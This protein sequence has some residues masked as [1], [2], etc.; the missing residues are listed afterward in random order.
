SSDSY[1]YTIELQLPTRAVTWQGKYYHGSDLKFYFVGSL[2]SFFNDTFGLT[3]QA[4]ASSLDTASTVVFG[5][6]NGVPAI[7]PQRPVRTQGFSTDLGLPLSRWF[8]ANPSGRGAG[9]TANLHY[10]RDMVPAREARRL[11]GVRGKSDMAVFTLIYK[12][13]PLVSFGVEQSLYRTIAANKAANSTGGLMTLRGIPSREWHDI[14]TE[15]A[16]S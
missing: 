14:R 12:L 16:R 10:S 6:R 2:N 13:N 11:G 15:T 7:A 1:G 5:L 9:W 3:G 4:T 8:R